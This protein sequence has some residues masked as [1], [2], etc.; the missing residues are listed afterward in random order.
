M[1]GWYQVIKPTINVW[2]RKKRNDRGSNTVTMLRNRCYACRQEWDDVG[3]S[4]T[5]YHV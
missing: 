1:Q 4:G 2:H 3:R 5:R